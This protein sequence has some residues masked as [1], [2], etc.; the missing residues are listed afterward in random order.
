MKLRDKTESTKFCQ[1]C[2]YIRKHRY[3]AMFAIHKL[4]NQHH[5][6][7]IHSAAEINNANQ[8]KNSIWKLAYFFLNRR[9]N[10]LTDGKR[11]GD[12][13]NDLGSCASHVQYTLPT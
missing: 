7:I 2:C 1:R 5:T 11:C 3:G 10:R 13:V 4:N 6:S 9:R 8:A 12:C